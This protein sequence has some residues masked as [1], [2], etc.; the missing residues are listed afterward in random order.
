AGW[1][2][3]VIETP[4]P[5]KLPA[6]NLGDGAARGDLRV[7]LDADVTVSP[8]LVAALVP[9]LDRPGPAYATGTPRIARSPSA[10][11]RAYARFWAR[12][13][14]V[15]DGTPG[16][17]CFAMNAA[18]RAQW[19][20]WPDIIADDMFA[21]LSFAPANRHRVAE[22]YDWP[23]VDGFAN[24]VRV[25]RRQDAGVA[26]LAQSFPALMAHEDKARTSPGL[27]GRLALRDP[28][29]LAAYAGVVLATRL[30]VLR[31]SGWV[32]GR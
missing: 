12:L 27:I 6:L 18:G 22:T 3:R 2:L 19:Q 5:G 1:D 7:Y 20:D 21:R 24:L 10:V 9:A 15:T 16:F 30:P 31:G 28:F 17:G 23:P 8:G 32:R 4:R 29:G 25:R 26:Q 13:P 14:F 11:T